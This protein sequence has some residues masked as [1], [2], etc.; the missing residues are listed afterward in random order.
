M[1]FGQTMDT[2]R[3]L[4]R[5]L[6]GAGAQDDFRKWIET[7]MSNQISKINDNTRTR[8]ILCLP[9]YGIP[10]AL[11]IQESLPLVWPQA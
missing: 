3:H 9:S 2:S 11:R 8:C 10:T 7:C 6:V 4:H 5:V 1:N